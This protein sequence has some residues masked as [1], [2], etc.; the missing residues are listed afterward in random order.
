[1]LFRALGA[2]TSATAGMAAAWIAAGSTGLLALALRHALVW[3][4]LAVAL[5]AGWPPS[6]RAWTH[7]ARLAAGV[8]AAVAMIGPAPD[9]YNV[10]AV[11]VVLGALASTARGVDRRLLAGVAGAVAAFGLYRLT[12]SSIPTLWSAADS[13]GLALGEAAEEIGRAHV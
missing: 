8:V 1:M 9:F 10:L 7:L 12:Q 11:A 5:G 6:P 3:L 4:A 13:C 2:V